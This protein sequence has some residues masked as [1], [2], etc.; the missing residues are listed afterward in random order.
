MSALVAVVFICLTITTHAAFFDEKGYSNFRA[1]QATQVSDP[2]HSQGQFINSGTPGGVPVS[3]DCA[4]REYAYQYGQQIQPRHGKFVGLFDAL[5]LQA[6]NQT[7]PEPEPQYIPN[8]HSNG[9]ITAGCTFFVDPVNGDDSNSGS[10]TSP[11]L[12][13]IKGITA[14]RNARTQ[15]EQCTLNLMKGVFYQTETIILTNQDSNLVI[16]N[17]NGADVTISGGI[18]LQFTGD[19]TL[20]NFTQTVWKNYSSA[21]NVWGRADSGASNDLVRYVGTFNTYDDCFAAVLQATKTSEGPFHSL[22]WH[23]KQQDGYEGMCYGIRDISWQPNFEGN[24]IYSARLIGKNIWSRTVSN[25][26]LLDDSIYGLRVNNNRAIRAR[27]PDQNPETSMQ[28]DPLSGWILYDTKWNPPPHVPN[29]KDITQTDKDWPGVEWP[30]D[31][32]GGTTWTGEGDWGEFFQGKGGPCANMEPDFGY[33]CAHDAPRQIEQHESPSAVYLSTDFFEITPNLDLSDAVVQAWRPNHW[34][35]WMWNTG[36]YNSKTMELQF[37]KG[38]FQ[39]GEGEKVGAEW[40]IENVFQ[41]LDSPTEYFYNRTTRK[42]YYFHNDTTQTP[43]PSTM[44]FVATYNKRLFNITGTMDKPVKGITIQ[45]ITM[46]DTPYTYM[47]PHGLPSGGDWA[48]QRQGA[49]T[50]QG[51]ENVTISSNLFTRLDGIGIFLS[52]YNRYALIDSNEF[53]WIGDSAMAS[54]G[55]TRGLED[56]LPGGGPDGRSGEQPRFTTIS[57]NLVHEIGIWEKQSSMWFQA[58][59]CQTTIKNNVFFNGP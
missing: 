45:G 46:R 31:G 7:R 37:S 15:N 11:F 49:I 58:Q 59:T 10:E 1:L 23:N 22:T 53:Q 47:D 13:I 17:Y 42:L 4:A 20:Y 2:P 38:G 14:T 30:M 40:Y 21:N 55:Y 9:A 29:A 16:Q 18:P 8:F 12:T 19:W 34:Y 33:W 24:G 6:C 51:T 50:L 39:G 35:T 52:G 54:W 27:Y 25:K 28:Y 57:N 48:I 43:P 56:E 36:S 32:P 3:F 41:F 44:Q 5:Q 26:N